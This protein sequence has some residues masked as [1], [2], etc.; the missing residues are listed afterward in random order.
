MPTTIF[1]ASVVVRLGKVY[2]PTLR[3]IEGAHGLAHREPVYVV[4]PDAEELG[5]ALARLFQDGHAAITIAE[6]HEAARASKIAPCARAAGLKSNRAFDRGA[7]HYSVDW[8]D[9]KIDLHM[10]IGDGWGRVEFNAT[11][12]RHLPAV[13]D[14]Y[15]IASVILEDARWYPSAW[16]TK[17]LKPGTVDYPSR[18]WVKHFGP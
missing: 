14:F 15:T 10:A 11:K 9:D 17:V 13:A 4:N 18:E 8:Q 16:G 1:Y 5:K 6:F 2:V 3:R 7:A 12:N